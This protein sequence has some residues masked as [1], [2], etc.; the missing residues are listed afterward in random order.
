VV[1]AAKATKPIDPQPQE[2]IIEP[3]YTED[4]IAVGALR[5]S[6]LRFALKCPSGF[7]HGCLA[8]KRAL[9]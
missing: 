5:E 8:G 6:H 2:L 7:S 9:R 3:R 4:F 1:A